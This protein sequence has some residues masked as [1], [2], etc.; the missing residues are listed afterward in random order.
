MENEF[1]KPYRYGVGLTDNTGCGRKITIY[2]NRT[3]ITLNVFKFKAYRYKLK[4]IS[5]PPS[6]FLGVY[7]IPN[8]EMI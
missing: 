7:V 5:S 8:K 1:D 6:M 3:A 4:D 2:Y